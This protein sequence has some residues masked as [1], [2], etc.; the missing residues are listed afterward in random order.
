MPIR[1]RRGVYDT[2]CISR[3][4]RNRSCACGRAS[5]ASLSLP[6]H[7][8]LRLPSSLCLPT[9]PTP[10]QTQIRFSRPRSSSTT[11]I[12]SLKQTLFAVRTVLSQPVESAACVPA[13]LLLADAPPSKT[14]SR[15]PVDASPER[16]VQ[17]PCS[18]EFDFSVCLKFRRRKIHRSIQS[19]V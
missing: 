1:W 9:Y 12:C 16:R 4:T 18:V 17:T 14:Q 8:C 2:R 15:G 7:P 6:L 10:D 3:E 5:P 19:S 13:F 11:A